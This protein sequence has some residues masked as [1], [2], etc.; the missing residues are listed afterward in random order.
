[1]AFDLIWQPT[2]ECFI[3]SIVLKIIMTYSMFQHLLFDYKVIFL[4]NKKGRINI[5]QHNF[6]QLKNLF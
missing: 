2:D 6:S 5:K 1:M 4:Y 3:F